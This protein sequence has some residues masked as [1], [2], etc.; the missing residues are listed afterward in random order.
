[1][2]QMN[3]H[4]KT[5]RAIQRVDSTPCSSEVNVVTW[6]VNTGVSDGCEI[7]T[8]FPES[9]SHQLE[10]IYSDPAS[11][12]DEGER[13]SNACLDYIWHAPVHEKPGPATVTAVIPAAPEATQSSSRVVSSSIRSSS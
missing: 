12:V 13:P 2:F 11:T 8:D 7:W 6:Q 3:P 9:V 10:K 1:M 4:T 5:E